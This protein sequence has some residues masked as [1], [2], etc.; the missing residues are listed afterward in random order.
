LIEKGDEQ[1]LILT[2][3]E[4]LLKIFFFVNRLIVTVS[5]IE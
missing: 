3:N 2:L 4:S 1:I 5:I